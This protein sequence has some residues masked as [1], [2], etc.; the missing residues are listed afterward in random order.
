MAEP[1]EQPSIPL[2]MDAKFE[3]LRTLFTDQHLRLR[4]DMGLGFNAAVAK[5]ETLQRELQLLQRQV[6]ELVT[7]RK[8]EQRRALTRSTW[9]GI[10][11]GFLFSALMKFADWLWGRP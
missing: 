4:E 7:L 10:V 11:A 1:N 6:D 5:S 8:E 3:S 9:A 2:W